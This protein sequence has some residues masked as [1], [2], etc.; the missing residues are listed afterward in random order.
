MAVYRHPREARLYVAYTFWGLRIPTP[1]WFDDNDNTGPKW[2]FM[3]W[4]W[5]RSKGVIRMRYWGRS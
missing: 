4:A 5:L 1:R 3:A 2:L